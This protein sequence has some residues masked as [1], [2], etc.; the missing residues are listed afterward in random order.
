MAP[1]QLETAEPAKAKECLYPDESYLSDSWAGQ[2]ERLL[3][4]EG[5]KVNG[6]LVERELAYGHDE[7]HHLG[8]HSISVWLVVLLQ[9]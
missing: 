7:H 5:Q 2:C 1:E 4:A 8:E 6:S 9:F 3:G